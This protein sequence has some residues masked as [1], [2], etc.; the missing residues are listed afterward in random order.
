MVEIS[1]FEIKTLVKQVVCFPT[2]DIR[3]ETIPVYAYTK[4]AEPEHVT[5]NK[6]RYQKAVN[7]YG[8]YSPNCVRSI[9]IGTDA[10]VKTMFDGTDVRKTFGY[11][12]A[13]KLDEL[14]AQVKTKKREAVPRL[15]SCLLHPKYNNLEELYIDKQVLII[16]GMSVDALEEM[17][18]D[19]LIRAVTNTQF[20]RK[21]FGCEEELTKIFP[22]IATL[23]LGQRTI[24]AN[25]FKGNWEV[26]GNTSG[27]QLRIANKHWVVEEKT[28]IKDE[29]LYR[30]VRKYMEKNFSEQKGV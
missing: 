18:N 6:G 13:R 28:Y 8:E 19:A 23:A 26:V 27:G 22:R 25:M 5:S 9:A 4:E 2:L 24:T 21:L 29:Q 15:L 14:T 16:A 1:D 12:G 30:Y 10:V 20:C 11:D 17:T 7:K 3:G